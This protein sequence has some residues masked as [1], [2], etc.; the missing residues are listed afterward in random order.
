VTCDHGTMPVPAPATALLLRGVPVTSGGIELEL[1]TPTGAAIVRT[2]AGSFGP[3]PSTRIDG[4]GYGAGSREIPGQ[5]N[6]LRVMLGRVVDEEADPFVASLER[7]QLEA[8]TTEIDDMSGEVYSYLMERLLGAGALDAHFTPIQMKK[9]RP[10]VRLEVLCDPS[11]TAEALKIV[12]E[13]T[14]TFGAKVLPVARY[15][16]PRRIDE[17]TTPFGPVRVKLALSGEEVIKASPEYE[18]CRQLA[19]DRRVPIRRVFAAATRAIEET[20]FS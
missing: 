19:E 5:T 12:L 8:I 15:C 20:Y 17:V 4:I 2:L 13:E 11:K 3:M 10:G 1:T 9:N 6:F 7:R 18:D 16:F 14:S